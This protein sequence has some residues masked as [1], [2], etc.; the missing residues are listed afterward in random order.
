MNKIKSQNK[1][2]ENS[3]EEEEDYNI[4]PNFEYEEDIIDDAEIAYAL[5]DSFEAF[6]SKKDNKPY[7]IYQN[8]GN[9]KLEVLK[10]LKNK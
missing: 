4:S 9:Q 3:E 2:D 7:L 6:M 1:L 10:V 8:K 5:I